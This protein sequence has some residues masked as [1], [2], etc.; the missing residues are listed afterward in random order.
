[1]VLTKADKDWITKAILM[2]TGDALEAV[3]FPK[4]E[5][6]DKKFENLD[7][8]L[9]DMSGQ[10]GSN[11]EAIARIERKLDRVTDHQAEVLDNHEKRIGKL[12]AAIAV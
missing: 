4:F 3:V 6:I 9:E 11:T 1:M 7:D 8:K 2:G 5:S 12:E 10:I